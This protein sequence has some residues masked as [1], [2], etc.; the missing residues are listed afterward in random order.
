MTGMYLPPPG[1]RRR[2]FLKKGL[3]GTALL[4]LGG[5][6][7]LF[8]RPT[9]HTK[10]PP[11]GLVTFTED[12]YA[13]L[14]A[15]ARRFVPPKEGFPSVDEVRP[16]LAADRMFARAPED[17]KKELKQLL[18]LFENGLGNFLFGFRTR[19]FTQLSP[20]EQDRVLAEW[21]DSRL[22]I[23]RSGYRALHVLLMT[24][25]YGAPE[26]WSALGYPGPPPGFHQ[27]DAPVWKGGG[28][29]RPFGNGVFV[30]TG[31]QP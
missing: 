3:F 31:G 12:E 10:P 4:A 7:F 23:R 15:I 26:T 27:P 14:D 8:M 20:D 5:G 18:G 16:A 21:R 19:P 9:R 29:P 28:E 17:A 25:Y 11:E 30:D 13:V 1:R 22:A 6:G 2:G 24:S